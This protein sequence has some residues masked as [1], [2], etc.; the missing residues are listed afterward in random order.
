MTVTWHRCAVLAQAVVCVAAIAVPRGAAAQ[1]GPQCNDFLKLRAEAQQK[2]GL[3]KAASQHKDDRKG[4]CTAV[5]RF[6][7]AEGAAVKFLVDNKTWCGIPEQVIADAKASHE[8]TLQFRTVVCSEAPAVKPKPPTLSDAINTP[9][10]DSSKNTKTGR[11]TFDTL[12]GNPLA[13]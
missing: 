10:V 8:K 12:T 1:A 6:S 13:R 9:S 4:M 11:G 3:V 7:A 2:A 5:E